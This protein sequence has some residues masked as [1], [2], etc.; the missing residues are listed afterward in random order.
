MPPAPYP[1]SI[2]APGSGADWRGAAVWVVLVGLAVGIGTWGIDRAGAQLRAAPLYG[3]WAWHPGWGLV[4]AVVV[5]AVGIAWGPA[6]AARCRWRLVPLA[7]GGWAVLWALALAASDGWAAVTA[8]LT[9]GHEYEPFAAQVDHLGPFVRTYV[10]QLADHPIHVQ[11]H[12]PGPVVVAWL[13]DRVGLGG[14][15]WLAAL[16]LLAWGVAIATALVAARAVAGEAA[17]RRAAP[18]LALL[19]AVVW[20][21]TSFDALFAALV[22]VAATAFV[23]ASV[24]AGRVGRV[25]RSPF[26]ADRAAVPFAAPR[27]QGGSVAWGL[28]AGVAAGVALLCTYGAAAALLPCV[29]VAL[30]LR[31]PARTWGA[32]AIG[33]AGPLVLAAAAGFWWPAGLAATGDRY[34]A[35]IASDRPALYLTLLGNPA[36][37]ALAAGPAVAAGLGAVRWRDGRLVWLPVAALAA[38]T[39]ADLTQMSRGEVE[40][41]W[42]PLVPWLALAAPGDRRGWLGAQVGVAVALQSTLNSPW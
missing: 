42:L 23:L 32:A 14:A 17:A 5:G 21:G 36:A 15:G 27:G 31:C 10:D 16:V 18:A 1:A 9:T 29:L 24:H 40:R 37:L 34:W 38:V 22:A 41:I 13:F 19:P 8:P 11:G 28:L 3:Q 4:P 39:L 26:A 6:V 7:A 30:L 35:G 33:A 20:A 25:G 12:P 2:A